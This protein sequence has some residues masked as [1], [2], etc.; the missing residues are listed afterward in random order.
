MLIN[1][2]HIAFTS[3]KGVFYSR[4]NNVMMPLFVDSV[5]KYRLETSCCLSSRILLRVLKI[6]KWKQG[7]HFTLRTLKTYNNSALKSPGHF[8]N[9]ASTT[10]NKGTTTLFISLVSSKLSLDLLLF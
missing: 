8:A 7:E 4:Y 9:I 1:L 5:F 10:S 3:E 2:R 6:S